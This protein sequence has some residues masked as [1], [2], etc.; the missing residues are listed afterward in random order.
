M[1]LPET[2]GDEVRIGIAVTV[3]PPYGPALVSA[4]TRF[5]DPAAGQ[6]P[7]H[8]TLLVPT[9]LGVDRLA[10]VDAHLDAVAARHSPFVMQLRG[11]ATF[12]P[13]SPVVF[14]QVVKG[15]ADCEQLERDV[16]SG[17]LT[18][19]LRFPY[20]PHVTV[21]HELDDE[22]LDTAFDGLADFEAS[23]VVDRFHRYLHGDDGVW[24]PAREYLLTAD[25]GAGP[26]PR[27]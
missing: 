11:T 24:R 5:G 21:A 22:D 19:E 26:G 8:V 27:P 17:M 10:R 25:A 1:N 23:F 18:Q 6:I 3:P 4:R 20:H 12:R 16:R 9:A 2:S 13:V 15:I 7:P 14:V